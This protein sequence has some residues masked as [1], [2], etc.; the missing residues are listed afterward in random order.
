MRRRRRRRS[1]A[2]RTEGRRARSRSHTSTAAPTRRRGRPDPRRARRAA[3]L[4]RRAARLPHRLL[5][6]W[7]S[8][9]RRVE[10]RGARGPR[11]PGRPGDRQRAPLSRSAPARRSRRADR[12]AQPPLLPRDAGSARSRGPTAT[13]A[14]SRSS[15]STSTTS[16]RSTTGSDTSRAT[17]CWP[18]R[19]RPRPRRRPHR[20]RR[21][22]RRRRRVRGDHARVVGHGRR[23]ALQ[24]ARARPSRRAPSGRRVGCTSRPAS[25]SC[26]PED[27]A[28][29][30][31][32]ARRRGALPR[33]GRR[34]GHGR[35]R[36]AVGDLR[37]RPAASLGAGERASA[38]TCVTGTVPVT[39]VPTHSET[40][41]AAS[42]PP[43]RHSDRPRGLLLLVER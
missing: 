32:R 43:S 19:L 21:V 4:R 28:V 13:A 25:P 40:A 38:R 24:A 3:V 16:R 42:R 7:S 10:C 12:A 39:S 35:R 23:P 34:Q 36:R 1:P 6:Q 11:A 33:Q 30:A 2:R 18:R 5:A 14:T 31:L 15:S 41:R 29:V 37:A 22:P 26:R 20:R 17:R 27:D 9:V 8:G